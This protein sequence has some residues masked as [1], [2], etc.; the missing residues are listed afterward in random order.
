MNASATSRATSIFTRPP[1]AQ[2]ADPA[3]DVLLGAEPRKGGQAVLL[4]RRLEL[5]HR[6]DAELLV[7]DHRLLRPE[8][9][10]RVSSRTPGGICSRSASSSE[11]PVARISWI[12]SPIDCRPTGPSRSRRDPCPRGPPG[13]RRRRGRPSRR[14]AACTGRR[15]GSTGGRRTPRASP[16]RRR[17]PAASGDAEQAEQQGLLR[18]QAVLGLVPHHRPR[19]VD[20][21]VGDL[22][23]DG[24][25][26]SDGARSPRGRRGRRASGRA[27]SWGRRARSSASRSCPMLVQTS[28]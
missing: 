22:L 1:A 2:A 16:R 11:V 9:G 27:G 20:H 3:G 8:P 17:S 23:A 6:P 19:S 18:V 24:R 4:D 15:T 10:D 13:S 21:L 26:G 28:V 12:F 14:R 7:E 25:A 5:L